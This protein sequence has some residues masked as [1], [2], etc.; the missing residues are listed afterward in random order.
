MSKLHLIFIIF[1]ALGLVLLTSCSDDGGYTAPPQMQDPMDDDPIGEDPMDFETMVNFVDAEVPYDS[2][3]E[4]NFFE[5]QL[6]AL[7]PQEDVIAYDLQSPLFS[8]Y[9][10]K[11]RFIWM[12]VGVS[13]TY[14]SDTQLLDFPNGTVMIKNFSYDN[15]QPSGSTRIVETRVMYKLNDTWEFAEYVWNEAQT[16]AFLDLD[17]SFTDISWIDENNMTRNVN[18]RIPSGGECFTCHK[19]SDQPIPIGLKPQYINKTFP[20]SDGAMNQ[21]QKFQEQGFLE[22]YPSTIETVVKWDDESAD[23]TARVRS[24]IDINCAH[25]HAQNSHCDYRPIRFAYNET[26]VSD[27]LGICV[28]P[29]Q[30]IGNAFTHIINS[31]NPAR[32]VLFERITSTDE[33]IRMPLLGRSINHDEG[34]ALI[35]EWIDQLEPGCE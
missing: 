18:Y 32:S 25:C 5:G 6:A 4:Y 17:G 7:N 24:Y 14:T 10:K 8:D 34:I 19:K 30:N 3:S 11:D 15:V 26:T 16:D 28:E 23:L 29:D 13:A 1:L 12:P 21:L 20:Y 35:Q 27:N 33:S 2:L 9:A 22:S 31:G